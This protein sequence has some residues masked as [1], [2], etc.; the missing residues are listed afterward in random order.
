M[1]KTLDTRIEESNVGHMLL[2][3]MG[4]EGAGLGK[5]EQ[6]IQNPIDAGEVRDKFSKYKGVGVALKG[7]AFEEYRKNRSYTYNRPR[8][9]R[10]E[11]SR[12]PVEDD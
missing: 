5:S 3:K 7:D 4:W 11:S 6:G 12:P 8:S 1:A 10:S 2:K 9:E